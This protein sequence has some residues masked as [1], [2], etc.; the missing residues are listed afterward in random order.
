MLRTL[1]INRT[2]A[3]TGLI[4]F[5]LLSP[6]ACR[7]NINTNNP[8]VVRA[9]TLLDASNT[10]VA[11]EDGLVAASHAVDALETL[12][13]AYY[14]KAKPLLRKISTANVQAVRKIQAFKN[15][16]ATADWRGGVLAVA[17]SV[18]TADLDAAQIK[19]PTTRLIVAGSI[20]TLIG[21]LN[22]IP[23]TMKQ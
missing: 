1:S 7:H 11:L 10:C 3:A 16:D 23:Q 15:G 13:P 4:L 21:V 8:Q 2:F 18:N 9:A 12:D 17:A 14:N 20:A 19:D 6:V 5:M 22:G